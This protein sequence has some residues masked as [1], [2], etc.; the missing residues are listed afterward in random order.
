MRWVAREGVGKP[1]RNL[2]HS[3]L[4]QLLFLKELSYGQKNVKNWLWKNENVIERMKRLTHK[5]HYLTK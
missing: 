1:G 3:I 5:R 2:I 4:I